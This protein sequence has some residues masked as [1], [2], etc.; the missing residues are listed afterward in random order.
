MY[1]HLVMTTQ[2]LWQFINHLVNLLA[3]HQFLKIACQLEKKHMLGA[4]SLLKVIESEMQAYLSATEGRVVQ[5]LTIFHCNFY[6]VLLFL[7]SIH[8]FLLQ[9]YFYSSSLSSF[10]PSS[11]TCPTNV[12]HMHT[13]G[14]CWKQIWN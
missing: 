9:R 12:F 6:L 4:Y 8:F 11:L 10:T 3:R 1:C 14:E 5:F 13:S 2:F 7:F